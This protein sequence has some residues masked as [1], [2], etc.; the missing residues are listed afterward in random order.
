MFRG[1]GSELVTD[2]ATHTMRILAISHPAV[3][4]AYRRKFELIAASSDVELRLVVPE[5]WPEEARRVVFDPTDAPNWVT[6]LPIAFEGYYTRYFFTRGIAEQFR[7]F[8]PDL[9]H[10]EEEPYSLSAG[11]ALWMLRRHTPTARLVFRTSISA[12]IR[13]KAVALPFLRMIE[14]AVFRR[15]ACGFVLSERAGEI[16]RR[17]GY[18][19]ET[20]V[21]P[22]GVDTDVFRPADESTRDAR[23]AELGLSG[24]VVGYVGRLIPVKGIET[25]LDAVGDMPTAT[26]LIVG[27][28]PHRS[29]LERRAEGLG[30]ADRVRFVGSH[31]TERVAEMMAAMDVFVLPS[32]TSATWVEFFGRVAVEAMAAGVPVIGSSSGEIPNTI[33][34]AGIVFPEGNARALAES[35]REVLT[36]PELSAELRARGLARV[37]ERYAWEAVARNTV[38]A[39]AEIMRAPRRT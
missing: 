14:S 11:Q 31:P 3:A 10:I 27:D 6:S 16:M 39:Y 17:H 30:L 4:R 25:L 5:A 36:C 28:G 1:P 22:N 9:V 19:G 12:D 20:R 18:R 13:L 23:K 21:F 2:W 24:D 33:A 29:V 32:R 38:E 7:D 26:V 37:R 34:D 15:A 35:I 8:R